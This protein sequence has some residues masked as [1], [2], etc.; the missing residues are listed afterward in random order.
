MTFLVKTK[1]E[2]LRSALRKLEK[3]T[4][5]T[6]VGPGSVARSFAEAVTSEIGD[7]YSA[8]D[9]NLASSVVSTA[10][11][12]A[13]DLLGQLY[14]T[15][16]KT[17]SDIATIDASIGAFYFYLDAPYGSSITIPIGTNVYTDSETYVGQQ[18]HFQT[19]Q[20]VTI[21]VGNTRAYASIR[22]TFSDSVFTAGP[23]TL[24]V[25]TMNQPLLT[26]VRCT[27]PKPISPQV[28]YEGDDSYRLR[29]IKAVR[30]A[31]G[32]TLEAVRF[33]GL[34]ISGVRDIA[35]RDA[36][37]GLGSF[38]GIVVVEDNALNGPIL[39]AAL[40]AMEQ[41]RPVGVRMF[42]R[43]PD[44]LPVDVFASIVLRPNVNVDRDQIARRVEIGI[45]RF[46]NKFLVGTPMVYN[47]LIQAV[48]DA[49]D[50]VSDVVLTRFS[51]NGEEVLRKNFT[52]ED[53]QQIIPGELKVS[54][55]AA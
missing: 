14:N 3:T 2:V 7:L 36:A 39:R 5:I 20:Q 52:I 28:G 29:I 16:R 54:V 30:V 26:T 46:L 55:A 33:A 47:Q 10:R 21:P 51:L 50:V 40:A 8:L 24:V 13:L 19:T 45:L 41:V 37:Y 15:Q 43:Q 32:G 22:P 9:F 49:T 42:I 31:A 18:Y 17:L 23:G 44:L 1:E 27:N 25:T 4:L 6:S 12:R 48:L 53:D 35:M 38:E 11:G 34:R